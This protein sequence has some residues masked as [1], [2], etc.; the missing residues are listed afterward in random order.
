MK[1]YHIGLDFGT[2][3]TKACVYNIENNLHEFFKFPQ[4]K[5]FFL[6]SMVGIKADSRFVYGITESTTCNSCYYYFKIAAAEDEEFYTETFDTTNTSHSSLYKN[7]EFYPFS[8]EFL[9]VIYICNVLFTI[10]ENYMGKASSDK[11]IKGGFLNK[12]FSSNAK[13][14]D[15]RFTIQ[16]G[17]PTE[18]SQ[19]KNLRRK[20]KFENIL[21]IAEL[22]QKEYKTHEAFLNA[23]SQELS[24]NVKS[25][26]GLNTFSSSKDFDDLLNSKGISVFPETGAGLTFIVKTRQ[27]LP[28][29][30]AIMDI[31]GGTTD[32]SFFSVEVGNSI[33]YL[34]S[35]SYIIAANNVYKH[36]ASQVSSIVA[37]HETERQVQNAISSGEW[38][39]NPQLIDA[40]QKVNKDLKKMVYKLFN[41]RIYHFRPGMVNKYN[42]QPIIMYGGGSR[43]PAIDNGTILIHDN[44][45]PTSITIPTAS[46]EKQQIERYAAGIN[47]LPEDR[48][49]EKDLSV[50]VVALGLSYI[51]P[52]SFADWFGEDEYQPKDS[53]PK[54]S[55]GIA[56]WN[57]ETGTTVAHP[58]NED[59]YL[60]D[61]LASKWL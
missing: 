23:T 42:D 9:S 58:F 61:V 34:A 21:L 11:A 20:R 33:K 59:R 5:T 54:K 35:E 10:K 49:W 15:V 51:K 43:L 18:W 22:L 40:L 31:G 4:N 56:R 41:K 50:L 52:Q 27:L 38:K 3:Q 17:I 12:L 46:L 19:I 26:Y 14:E 29:Y 39:N 2:Y 60:W 7:E 32:I 16:L 47:I 37:L 24:N 48:S 25:I 57:Q 28:G 44:G 36:L 55:M 53:K 1:T 30:Y 45:S 6:P 8:P 13:G